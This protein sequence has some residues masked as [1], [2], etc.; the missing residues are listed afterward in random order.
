MAARSVKLPRFAPITR[1]SAQST[2]SYSP[3]KTV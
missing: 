3:W 2:R 1:D